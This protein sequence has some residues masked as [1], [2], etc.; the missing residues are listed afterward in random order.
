MATVSPSSLAAIRPLIESIRR[1]VPAGEAGDIG[2]LVY[3]NGSAKA[4]LSDA[5][6]AATAK[7]RGMVV[8]IGAYG[9]TSFVL[10][11]MLDVCFYGPVAGFSGL[12]PGADYYVSTT[13]GVIDDTAPAG[14]SGDYK[15]RIGFALDAET[16]FICPGTDD[17]AAQ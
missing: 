1:P 17:E 16:L 13:P 4:A 9:N 10:N 11:D 7:A 15:W 14:A 3:I 2:N 8:G 5:D 12:T 6:A